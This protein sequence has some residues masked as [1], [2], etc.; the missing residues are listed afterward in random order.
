MPDGD[1]NTYAD[2]AVDAIPTQGRRPEC[3]DCWHPPHFRVECRCGCPSGIDR[4]K[5]RDASLVANHG[6]AARPSEGFY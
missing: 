2:H 6:D 1:G 4:K 3:P 5:E